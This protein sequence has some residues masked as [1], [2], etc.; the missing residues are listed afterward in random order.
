MIQSLNRPGNPG[1]AGFSSRRDFLRRSA[2]LLLGGTTVLAGCAAPP[3]EEEPIDP[4]TLIYPPPPADPRFH[5]DRTIWGSNDVVEVTGTDRL[6]RFAT[7]ESVRGKGF[8]KPFGV[9]A[10]EGRI[11]VS[12]TVLRHVHVYDY[13]RK[14]YYEIG[15]RGLGRLVKPLGVALDGAGHVY[16]MD[17]TAKR[18]VIYDLEG[19]YVNAVGGEDDL[20]RPSGIAVNADGSRIYVLD[21]GGVTSTNHRVMVY[22]SAGN[23]VQVIGERG[24]GEGQFNLPLACTTDKN[25]N[26]YVL[27]TGN[28]RCQVFA[29]DGSFLR[30]F[31]EAG[32]FPGQ[33]GHPRGITVDDDGIIYISDTAFGLVQLFTNDGRILM[34]LGRRSEQQGPGQFILPAGIGVDVDHRV[35]IAD[36]FFRKVDVFRPYDLP[37]DTPIGQPVALDL[38]E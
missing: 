26:L 13:P 18:A 14:R 25:D 21:T 32:R 38:L 1:S 11:Y 23:V 4:T 24:G 30:M 19:N 20:D 3:P 9:V 37:E 34:S 17:G 5:Y 10:Q 6:R 22:N 12:D 36:Q 33:F 7:G 31:G 8:A 27:D 15:T 16:V 35:Y 2:G 28:F 29:P